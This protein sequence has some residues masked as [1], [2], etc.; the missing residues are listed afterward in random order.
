M[1]H[2]LKQFANSSRLSCLSY[3]SSVILTTLRW[4]QRNFLDTLIGY[5]IQKQYKYELFV[6][7]HT[8][9]LRQLMISSKTK[10]Y[11]TNNNTVQ[12]NDQCTLYFYLMFVIVY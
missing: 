8:N 6:Q 2:T 10:F 11:S 3:N 7:R 9:R 4:N 1:K 12:E 5:V